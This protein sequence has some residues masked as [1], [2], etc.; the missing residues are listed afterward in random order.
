MRL[1]QLP[2]N[3]QLSDSSTQTK[4]VPWWNKNSV[5]VLFV[6]ILLTIPLISCK[7]HS[8]TASR[9]VVTQEQMGETLY[10][11]VYNQEGKVVQRLLR[12]GA[13][14]NYFTEEGHW[15]CL[16]I[17]AKSGNQSIVA[18]LLA[19]GAN[20]SPQEERGWTPIHFAV[21][22]KHIKIVKTLLANGARLDLKTTEGAT[23][24][25][26]AIQTKQNDI[27]ELFASHGAVGT[28]SERALYN[29]V[30]KGD[31]EKTKHLIRTGAPVNFLS[32]PDNYTP[33]HAAAYSGYSTIVRLLLENGANIEGK[34]ADSTKQIRPPLLL[35]VENGQ[36]EVVSL[37]IDAGANVHSIAPGGIS[38]LTFAAKDGKIEIAKIL[39]QH[40]A[41][42]NDKNLTDPPLFYA[43]QNGHLQMAKLLIKHGAKINPYNNTWVL[44]TAL[45]VAAKK[46]NLEMCKL[47][48][49]LGAKPNVLDLHRNTALDLAIKSGNSALV[50]YLTTQ[51]AKKGET[52]PISNKETP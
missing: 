31:L 20:P 24:L 5:L 47:L 22:H 48:I 52:I 17:A 38:A 42:P 40:H 39:L 33:L 9:R 11:A 43:V 2:T 51:G 4:P 8:L 23:P 37:L 44:R 26:L 13:D 12:Q 1:R 25:D 15:T 29:A 35:A 41:D 6:S 19:S 30:V 14:V 10:R 21:Y 16:H 32:S 34:T 36:L 49:A 3:A 27:A 45:H 18:M 7:Q 46:G 28:F 50:Q